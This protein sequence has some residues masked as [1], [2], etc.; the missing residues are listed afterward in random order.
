MG[1]NKYKF[2][3]KLVGYPFYEEDFDEASDSLSPN[4]KALKKK[5]QEPQF[6]GRTLE[7]V[8]AQVMYGDPTEIFTPSMEQS[9]EFSME[10]PLA[11]IYLKY[12]S[13]SKNLLP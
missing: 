3:A 8:L 7:E 12:L 5:A 4:M 11:D 9:I 6:A 13:A 1:D 2:T 10:D